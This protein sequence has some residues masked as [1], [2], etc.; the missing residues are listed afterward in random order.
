MIKQKIFCKECGVQTEYVIDNFCR[1][2]LKPNHNMTTKEY[3]DKHIKKENEG[4]C[5][6]CRK[7]TTFKSYTRGY[8]E[9]CSND[10][11]NTSEEMG[12]RVS[13]S[14]K[15]LNYEEVNA[16]IRKTM[17]I[18]YGVEHAMHSKE[19]KEKMQENNLGKYGTKHTINLPHV[20]ESAK[21]AI[22]ENFEE[23][24]LRRGKSIQSSSKEANKKRKKTVFDKYGVDSISKVK[25]FVNKARETIKRK[26]G[27][28]T[29]EELE[30]YERYRKEVR[31]YTNSIKNTIIKSLKCY[32]TNLIMDFETKDS[33]NKF[34]ATIDHKKSIIYGFKNNIDP[35]IIGCINNL[36]F[37]CR[38]VNSIKNYRCEE[39]FKES[40][41]F[42]K[43]MERISNGEFNS[44]L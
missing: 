34:Q 3:Y 32:Y 43:I 7:E 15:D 5:L 26:Y 37:C 14:K 39:E 33:H 16:K 12:K 23:I 31:R 6:K 2:H 4:K 25:E 24:N 10:C 20:R 36:C 28:K 13:D 18:K 9:F 17:M 8:A 38:F 41:K 40:K 27:F 30:D 42:I 11:L 35:S 21:L 29:D 19:L 22:E 1:Y 44:R